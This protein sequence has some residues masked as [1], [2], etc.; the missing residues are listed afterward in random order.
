[1]LSRLAWPCKQLQLVRSVPSN[2]TQFGEEPSPQ[3]QPTTSSRIP[4]GAVP[5]QPAD[6]QARQLQVINTIAQ[7]VDGLQLKVQDP[8]SELCSV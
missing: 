7:A 8:A 2:W 1:M 3:R 6:P 5:E 4:Q